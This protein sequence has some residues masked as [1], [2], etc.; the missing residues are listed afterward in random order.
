[1]NKT[2]EYEWS[3]ELGKASLDAYFR[4][5]EGRPWLMLVGGLLFFFAG[6]HFINT[7]PSQ[8]WG[9]VFL[10]F[11]TIF[12]LRPVKMFFYKKRLC[13]D[14]V[15]LAPNSKVCIEI[16]DDHLAVSTSES[17][18]IMKWKSFTGAKQVQE[19]TFI[20]SGKILAASIP[21]RVLNQSDID[22]IIEKISLSK[23]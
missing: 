14:S 19:F 6:I 23:L 7:D 21:S 16:T 1:M 3:Q 2:L 8:A 22:F 18:R 11:G 13:K 5:I 20:Y 15:R 12:L 17:N 4:T 10:L 9:L